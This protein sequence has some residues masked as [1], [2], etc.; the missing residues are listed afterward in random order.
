MKSKKTHLDI[1]QYVTDRIIT[2][3]ENGVRPWIK[4]WNNV[5]TLPQNV[6]GRYYNG[7]NILLLQLT[8]IEKGYTQSK[9][10]SVKKINKLGGKIRK[11]EKA[12]KIVN[13]HPISKEKCDENG[14]VILD[15]NGYPEIEHFAFITAF[16]VFNIE[17]C[18]NLPEN[19]FDKPQTSPSDLQKIAK[20]KQITSG[21]NVKIN[22]GN[23]NQAYYK[24]ST[25]SIIMPNRSQFDTEQNYYSVLLHEIVHATGHKDRLNRD[26]ITSTKA[27]FGN[28]IYA[29]EELIAEMGSAFLCTALGFDT[30]SNH[31]NYIDSWLKILKSDKKAI[32]RASGHARR[33]IDYLLQ[34]EEI[35]QLQ[36]QYTAA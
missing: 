28:Q 26:G 15:E 34:I 10:I 29:F 30:I 31:A 32:F 13:Y 23:N 8:A 19:L 2:A 25:D 1:Y 20:V 21:M 9:W 4:P 7:I 17:Q 24:P 27:K 6:S 22:H 36:E 18:E 11:G 12:T 33:A 16:S 35:M 14:Q 3:L 5:C